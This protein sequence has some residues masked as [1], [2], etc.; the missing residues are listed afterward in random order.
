MKSIGSSE[1]VM[2]AR[3][4][5]FHV[6]CFSCAECDVPLRKGEQYCIRDSTVLCRH[7]YESTASS[8]LLLTSANV[9]PFKPTPYQY[10]DFNM[11]PND[12]TSL[13]NDNIP[14]KL[15]TGNFFTSSTHS[16][17]QSPRQKGRPRKRKPKDI[18][19]IASNPGKLRFKNFLAS[20]FNCL[21]NENVVDLAETTLLN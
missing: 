20:N 21:S 12:Q 8:S 15:N 1:F 9:L 17:T 6:N 11:S 7:H 18:E 19:S 4:L 3:H 5:V 14:M 10:S 13:P 16:L 2:R